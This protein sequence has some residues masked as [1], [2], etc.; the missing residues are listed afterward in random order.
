MRARLLPREAFADTTYE[1][2]VREIIQS[3]RLTEAYPGDKG[4]QEIITAYLNNNFYGNSTYGVKAAAKADARFHQTIAASLQSR[5][6]AW[7]R[8][9][10]AVNSENR[11][12]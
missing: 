4:K 8:F 11:S 2:K 3:I 5:V 9:S 7:T 10:Q 1:R 12:K 6:C